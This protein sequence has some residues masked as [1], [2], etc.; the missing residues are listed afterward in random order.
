MLSAMLRIAEGDIRS[1][2]EQHGLLQ[3]IVATNEQEIAKKDVRIAELEECV[4]AKQREIDEFKGLF[5]KYL[6]K[7][8]AARKHSAF[9]RPRVTAGSGG[10]AD[11]LVSSSSSSS[12]SSC[13]THLVNGGSSIGLPPASAAGLV[14]AGRTASDEPECAQSRPL[15]GVPDDEI[16]PPPP[17]EDAPLSPMSMSAS[18]SVD[19]APPELESAQAEHAVEEGLP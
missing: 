11:L 16:V 1:K 8:E 15:S 10:G 2:D 3:Q 9:Q 5:N 6:S 12:S 4:A 18:V 7:A 13:V 17:T 14:T 19:E